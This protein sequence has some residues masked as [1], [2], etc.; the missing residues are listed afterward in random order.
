MPVGLSD[1][2]PVSPCLPSP[3]ARYR[4]SSPEVPGGDDWAEV[5]DSMAVI[6]GDRGCAGEEGLGIVAEKGAAV[7]ML[8]TQQGGAVSLS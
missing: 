8:G 3:A 2:R 5:E 7:L 1:G 4:C 6:D